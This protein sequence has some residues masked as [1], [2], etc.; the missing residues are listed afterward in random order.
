MGLRG[1]VPEQIKGSNL[2]AIGSYF[3]RNTKYFLFFNKLKQK[4]QIY[5]MK[6]VEKVAASGQ[7]ELSA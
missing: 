3:N 2:N 7:F 4:N 1:A 6:Y 5:G